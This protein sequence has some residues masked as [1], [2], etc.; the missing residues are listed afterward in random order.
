MFLPI[1]EKLRRCAGCQEPYS[2]AC[3]APLGDMS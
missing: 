3:W 2:W 1:N